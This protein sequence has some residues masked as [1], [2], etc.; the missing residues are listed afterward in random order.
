MIPFRQ[1]NY[2]INQEPLRPI[3]NIHTIITSP[4]L[5]H[6]IDVDGP[7]TPCGTG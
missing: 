4:Y 6:T 1:R 7:L 2:Y 5:I 3:R